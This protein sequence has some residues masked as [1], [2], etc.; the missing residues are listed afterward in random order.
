MP[1]SKPKSRPHLRR[2]LF[3]LNSNIAGEQ[4]TFRRVIPHSLDTEDVFQFHL[5]FGEI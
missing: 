4:W 2:I 3:S 5:G 1:I